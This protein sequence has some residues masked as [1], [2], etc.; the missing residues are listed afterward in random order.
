M[1]ARGCHF[2]LENFILNVRALLLLID[3]TVMVPEAAVAS[4]TVQAQMTR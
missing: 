1:S 4:D 2:F 3:I